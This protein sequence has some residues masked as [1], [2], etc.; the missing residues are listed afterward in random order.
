MAR[1]ILRLGTAALRNGPQPPPAAATEEPPP[2]DFRALGDSK[3]DAQEWIEAAAAY[4]RFLEAHPDDSGIWIQ[5]GNCYKEAGNL[6]RSLSAYR[7]AEQIDP[8]SFEVHLQLGHLYKILGNLPA[9]LAAYERAAA[10][11][12]DFGEVRPEIRQVFEA[13]KSIGLA[14]QI[15]LDFF[16]SVEELVASL[17]ARPEGDDIFSVYFRAFGVEV[18]DQAA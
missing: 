1:K 7:K 3:R 13:M 9:A 17:R 2:V 14:T 16:G 12:P 11:N 6:S 4:G 15:G 10:L 8:G 5:A 18:A